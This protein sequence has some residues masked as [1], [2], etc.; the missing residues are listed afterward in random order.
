MWIEA[1]ARGCAETELLAKVGARPRMPDGK[2]GGGK[3]MH[4]GQLLSSW[5]R[6]MN[7]V[8]FM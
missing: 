8:I 7:G 1:Q 6:R 2:W 5:K 4:C 3:T